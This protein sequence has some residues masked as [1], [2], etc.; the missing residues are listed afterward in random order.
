MRGSPDVRPIHQGTSGPAGAGVI[1]TPTVCAPRRTRHAEMSQP[2]GRGR[3]LSLGVVC[4]PSTERAV[5]SLS[6][7]RNRNRGL[8]GYSNIKMPCCRRIGSHGCRSILCVCSRRWQ[9]IPVRRS[10]P[11]RSCP[12]IERRD[13]VIMGTVFWWRDPGPVPPRVSNGRRGA[14]PDAVAVEQDGQSRDL[15]RTRDRGPTVSPITLRRRVEPGIVVGLCLERSINL[16]VGMLGILKSGGR[17]SRWMP[18]IRP[19]GWS[20][21]CATARSACWSRSR[22]VGRL[23]ATNPHTVCLDSEW[24]QIA[25]LPD[26]FPSRAPMP[27]TIWPM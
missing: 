10:V 8:S 25:R 17:I 19:S 20:T 16:I 24:D 6:R 22:T 15:S 14:H 1:R 13:T 18:I 21:C 23:P 11:C 27:S 2:T 7:W 12:E 4:H 5:R 9:T 26:R 3:P